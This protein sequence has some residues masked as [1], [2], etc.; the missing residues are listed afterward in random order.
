MN[1]AASQVTETPRQRFR[2]LATARTNAV[3][4]KLDILGHCANRYS[5]EYT[6]EDIN[7]IFVAIESSL[8]EVKR[9]FHV[10]KRAEFKLE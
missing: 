1:N 9:R 10:P 5:Y 7:K 6:E 2:R 4:K 8:E 3:I